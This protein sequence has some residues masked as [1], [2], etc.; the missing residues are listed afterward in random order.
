M[1]DPVAIPVTDPPLV[2]VAIDVVLLVHVPPAAG[3][4]SDILEPTQTVVGPVIDPA[5]GAVITVTVVVALQPPTVYE[6]TAVPPDM[7]AELTTP[8]EDTVAMLV[9]PLL[10]D[11]PGVASLR[12]VVDPT[13]NVVAPAIA[14]GVGFTVSPCVVLQPIDDV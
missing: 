11:P 8:E 5:G 14:G 7:L 6:I 9:L 4:M 13:Q 2:T 10:H 1:V 12:L 3:S